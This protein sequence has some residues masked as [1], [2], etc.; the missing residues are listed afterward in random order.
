MEL[1]AGAR[2]RSAADETQGQ[3]AQAGLSVSERKSSS[4]Q[5]VAVQ[6]EALRSFLR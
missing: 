6:Q 2:L 3:I 1:K 4:A 5:A